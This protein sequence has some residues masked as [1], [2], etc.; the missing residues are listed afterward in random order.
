MASKTAGRSDRKFKAL[1]AA[2]LLEGEANDAPCW[3]CTQDIDYDLPAGDG[4][5]HTLDHFYPVSTHPE[6]ANDPGNFRHAHHACNSSR[7]NKAVV[8]TIGVTTRD[9]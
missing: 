2:F 5:S 7:G 3:L 1:R 8:Q 6:Y 4:Q 9:W